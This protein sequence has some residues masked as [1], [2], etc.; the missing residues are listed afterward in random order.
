VA[1]WFVSHRADF[2]LQAANLC[3]IQPFADN[4]GR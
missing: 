2:F 4:Q 1:A 3:L